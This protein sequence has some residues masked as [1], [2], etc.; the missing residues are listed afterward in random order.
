MEFTYGEDV[1][2]WYGEDNGEWY[3][4]GHDVYEE[5]YNSPYPMPDDENEDDE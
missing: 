5:E 3:I 1:G 2:K 4:V